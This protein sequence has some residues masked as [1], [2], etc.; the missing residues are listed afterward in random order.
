MGTITI[1]NNDSANCS[2]SADIIF[3][4]PPFEMNGDQLNKIINNF[5]V[6]HLI[7]ITTLSQLIDYLKHSNFELSFD[8]V[9]DGVVPKKSKNI[10][11]PNYVHQTGVYLKKPKESSLFNRK[12]RIR[13]D[14]FSEGY[15]PTILRAPRE[16]LQESGYAKS[17]SIFT[18]ILG[19]FNVNNVIDPFGGT[20]TTALACEELNKNC[21]SIEKEKRLCESLVKKLKFLGSN[22][23]KAGF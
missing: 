15:W 8:F 12:L 4:D 14:T 20:G 11:Q 19:S 2:G 9:L 3:T 1:I 22:I 13:S 5:N 16:N 23:Q 10:H 7:L 6:N 17:L 21:I 18:D